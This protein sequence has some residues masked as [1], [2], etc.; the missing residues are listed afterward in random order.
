[1]TQGF[2]FRPFL[3]AL[4]ASKPAPIIT[5]GLEVLVQLVMAAMTTSPSFSWLDFL[6]SLNA[7]LNACGACPSG[8]LSCGRLGPDTLVTTFDRS[9]SMISVNSAAGMSGSRHMPCALQ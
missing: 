7:L 4:R 1:M 8:T 6:P 3:T 9:I 5:E 2:T